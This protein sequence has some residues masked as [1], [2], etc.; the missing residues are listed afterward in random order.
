MADKKMVSDK[1]QVTKHKSG[2]SI[3]TSRVLSA[4]AQEKTS[5]PVTVRSVSGRI[6]SKSTTSNLSVPLYSL[7]G[8]VAGTLDLPKEIFGVKVNRALLTQAARVYTTNQK[9][10]WSNTKTR[11]EVEGSTRKIF[12]QKGTGR[13][14]HG[15][16]RAPIFVGG[17]IALGP[18]S[19]KT[20]LNLPKKMK[21]A[22]LLSALSAKVQANEVF[23]LTDLRKASGKTKE[24]VKLIELVNKKSVLIV[25]AENN[26]MVMRAVRNIQGATFLSAR[27]INVFEVMKHQGLVLTGE[28]ADQLVNRLAGKI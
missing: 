20:L 17:G 25:D 2:V 12:K 24:M 13:A 14:R 7:A 5:K 11:G 19:R 21:K 3:K 28:A 27:E 9:A 10:H 18:K 16:V 23:G 6:I 4:S 1:K 26:E 8:K 22:S 15:S